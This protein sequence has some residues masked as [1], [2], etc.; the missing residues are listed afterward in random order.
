MR[1]EALGLPDVRGWLEERFV[2]MGDAKDYVATRELLDYLLTMAELAKET[3]N[4]LG[5]KLTG[6]GVHRPQPQRRSR[7]TLTVCACARAQ[8]S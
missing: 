1:D 8:T 7:A 2:I 3:D 4:S 6:A 5:R